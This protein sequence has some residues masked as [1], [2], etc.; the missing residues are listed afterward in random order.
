MAVPSFR[1]LSHLIIPCNFHFL[2]TKRLDDDDF[3]RGLRG[4][5]QTD[6]LGGMR[7]A[8]SQVGWQNMNF[9][10]LLWIGLYI[11]AFIMDVPSHGDVKSDSY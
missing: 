6:W 5:R 7:R 9:S 3:P 2:P 11:C 10:G 4:G 8:S 1:A